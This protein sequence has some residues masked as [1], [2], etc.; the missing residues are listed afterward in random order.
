M[1]RF[2]SKKILVPLA[3]LLVLLLGAI[4]WWMSWTRGRIV[5]A[6]T[7]A[8]RGSAYRLTVREI[9]ASASPPYMLMGD[10]A[11]YRY[12]C[13]LTFKGRIPITSCTFFW[14]SLRPKR[15]AIDWARKDYFTIVF[16]GLNVI[17]CRWDYGC[18]AEWGRVRLANPRMRSDASLGPRR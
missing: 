1:H 3:V 4:L 6:K 8:G 9:P 7:Y 12:Y 13:E 10:L 16:D 18:R 17:E 14:D 15:I 5:A 2:R 11:D